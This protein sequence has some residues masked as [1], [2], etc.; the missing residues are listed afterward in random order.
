MTRAIREAGDRVEQSRTD[1]IAD[2]ETGMVDTV[3]EGWQLDQPLVAR[4][5]R[6]E[7]IREDGVGHIHIQVF[8]APVSNAHAR[9]MSCA[10]RVCTCSRHMRRGFLMGLQ[11]FA[12]IR[13]LR[14]ASDHHVRH[15]VSIRC[16]GR[17]VCRSGAN[18]PDCDRGP[19]PRIGT[20]R[21]S[22]AT[23]DLDI[24]STRLA[25]AGC[26][27]IR[28]ETGSG[29]SRTGRAEL[30]T[31]LDFLQD[32]DEL[33]VQRLDRRGRSTRDVLNLVHDLDS[34]GASLR[35]LEPDVTTGGDLGRLVVT[36]LGMVA[37][38]ELKFIRDRQRAGIDA[39]KAKGVSQGRKQQIDTDR[40]R[41][42]VAQ[43]MPKAQIAR[44]LK[45]PRMSVY[46]ALKTGQ[47]PPPS[48]EPARPA[49][50]TVNRTH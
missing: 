10:Q 25:A 19:M 44:T 22:T 45:I 16:P 2:L 37:D 24:Q 35:V 20:A 9:A 33:V 8:L 3:P 38:L 31:I 1:D 5:T 21:V 30:Q 40:I 47:N 14:L 48:A 4:V 36:V 43:N 32:G 39:A 6:S 15:G 41:E 23:Q 27:V 7:F 46:R 17:D 28:T 49:D 42:L 18:P 50:D 29:S 11:R 34:K 26:Q 13:D 12:V